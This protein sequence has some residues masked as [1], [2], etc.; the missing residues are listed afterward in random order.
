MKTRKIDPTLRA[1]ET[2]EL[3]CIAHP[4]S[5]AAVRRPRLFFKT[6]TWI[7]LLGGS[8]EDGIAG[9]GASVE[10]ALRAFDLIYQRALRPPVDE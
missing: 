6:G 5:P 10:A 3:Y 1:M 8:I 9:F 4:S 7:A 2:M